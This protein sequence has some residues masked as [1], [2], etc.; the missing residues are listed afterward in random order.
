MTES[1]NSVDEEYVAKVLGLTQK[2]YTPG[3]QLEGVRKLLEPINPLLAST[4]A[5]LLSLI[6]AVRDQPAL[7]LMREG[8]RFSGWGSA[9]QF[10]LQEDEE[11][12][13]FCRAVYEQPKLPWSD[14]PIRLKRVYM[15]RTGLQDVNIARNYLLT[16]AEPSHL[17]WSNHQ[18][19]FIGDSQ[20]NIEQRQFAVNFSEKGPI[21]NI[22]YG[23][24]SEERYQRV[25]GLR[26]PDSYDGFESVPWMFD[27]KSEGDRV[28]V[29]FHKGRAIRKLISGSN[30]LLLGNSATSNFNLQSCLESVISDFSIPILK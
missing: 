16:L 26:I 9:I 12:L 21:D 5:S 11:H 23:T 24:P 15:T 29:N 25:T 1:A 14:Q 6:E 13:V 17:I 7:Q 10:A 19:T 8:G 3:Q 18:P 2:I 20:K 28:E 4:H 30:G 27:F 22:I